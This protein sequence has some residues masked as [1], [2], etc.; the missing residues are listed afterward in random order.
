MTALQKLYAE[1]LARLGWF[2]HRYITTCVFGQSYADADLR[3]VKRHLHRQQISV[4]D[5]RNGLTPE[6]KRRT[7]ELHDS[8]HPTTRRRRKAG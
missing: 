2:S 7:Q 6:S 5:A 1:T 4:R 3:A 8:V